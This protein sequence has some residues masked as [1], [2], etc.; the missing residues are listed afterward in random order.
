VSKNCKYQNWTLF[1]D[2]D[3]VINKKIRNDY[4]SNWSEFAFL[5][6]VPSLIAQLNKV[7]SRVIIISN[8]Q[9][10]GKKLMTVADLTAV[11]SRMMAGILLSGGFVDAIYCCPH[12]AA[13]ECVCRK[14]RPGM[15]N[16]AMADFKD[17]K[18][19]QSIFIGDSESD[20]R[21]GIAMGIHS[22][23]LGNSDYLR[24]LADDYFSDLNDFTR[25]LNINGK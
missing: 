19:N 6:D 7:F 10:I 2:R 4:V 1:L 24:N 13:A 25:N 14:P 21:L 5:N 15:I 20:I 17:I 8:Q 22:I 16:R 11:H 3:G 12:I 9:G 23:Y 18:L